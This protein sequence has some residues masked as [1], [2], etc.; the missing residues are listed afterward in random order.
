MHVGLVGRWV[1]WELSVVVV[2]CGVCLVCQGW[3][4]VFGSWWIFGV[5][6]WGGRVVNCGCR[7]V[8][9]SRPVSDV[10][11]LGLF[12]AS[13]IRLWIGLVWGVCSGDGCGV[14]V[15]AVD[16]GCISWDGGM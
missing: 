2:A 10:V 6:G 14:F 13:R 4:S 12:V 5:F 8:V 9:R 11:Q 7:R 1:W 16:G 3:A 15:S